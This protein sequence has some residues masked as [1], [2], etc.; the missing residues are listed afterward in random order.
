MI[1][2]QKLKQGLIPPEGTKEG[3]YC[4]DTY[5]W[6][7]DC[8]RIPGPDGLDWNTS[9]AKPGDLGDSGHIVVIRKNRIWRL[10]AAKDGK[11]L[12]TEDLTQY[13]TFV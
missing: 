10:E 5:R 2:R 1:F 8:C 4:M 11:I 7:F 12:S 13:V 6:M 9:F 3:P